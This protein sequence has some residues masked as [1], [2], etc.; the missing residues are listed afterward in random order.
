MTAVLYETRGAVAY[1]T[2]NRPERRNALDPEVVCRL[3]D[4][5][6]AFEHDDACRVAIVTGAGDTAFSAGADL[7][8][9]AP[10]IHG[11][12]A[13]EDEWDHRVAAA[14]FSVMR[15][16]LKESPPTKP[17]IAAA[18]GFV[19]AGGCEL[20]LGCDLRV[21]SDDA[22]IGL[23]EAKRGLIPAGG[24]VVRL[25]RAVPRA[26]ALEMLLTGEPIDATEALRHGLVNRVVPAGDVIATAEA[27]AQ[28][29]VE[30]SPV[31]V[32]LIKDIVDST[33]GAEL[34]DAFAYE[35]KSFEVIQRSEDAVE[36]PLAFVEKRK[37][38]FTGRLKPPRPS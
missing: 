12:R 35:S 17:I 29:I 10:L 33:D 37:P 6:D 8:R 2:I 32:R 7:A 21:V 11:R 9:L 27:M 31:S 26:I 1:V 22:R 25:A 38:N 36:G 18:R 4:A 34:N 5:W 3:I 19:L 16:I 14:P 23:T 28:V 30:N 24:G 13:P 15:A 20:M